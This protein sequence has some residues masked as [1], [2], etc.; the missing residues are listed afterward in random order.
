[1]KVGMIGAGDIAQIMHLPYLAE[2]PE[3]D[4]HAIADLGTNVVET[5][6]TPLSKSITWTCSMMG[7]MQRRSSSTKAV[8]GVFSKTVRWTGSGTT[9]EFRSIPPNRRLR[10]RL[11]MRLLAIRPPT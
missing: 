9:N 10:S 8:G 1:M 3:V 2:I 5:L 6:G 4:L 7:D 11:E